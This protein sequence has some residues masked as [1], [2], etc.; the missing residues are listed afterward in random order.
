MSN[1]ITSSVR[2]R[3][4]AQNQ[5]LDIS[6]FDYNAPAELFPTRNKRFATQTRYKRFDTAAEAVRFAVEDVPATA[7]HGAYLEVDE[8]RFGVEEIHS[9]YDN[10]AFP[11]KRASRTKST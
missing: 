8:E 5:P 7:L 1:N 9:L 3:H 2:I 4:R 11:L 10:E 6:R